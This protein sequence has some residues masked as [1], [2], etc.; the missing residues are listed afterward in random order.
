MTASENNGR[1]YIVYKISLFFKLLGTVHFRLS[2]DRDPIHFHFSWISK[3]SSLFTSRF[4][5]IS[6]LRSFLIICLRKWYSSRQEWSPPPTTKCI[7]TPGLLIIPFLLGHSFS[8]LYLFKKKKY[9]FIYF[10]LCW[11]FVSVRGLSLVAASGGHSSSRC[12]GLSL[13]R[14]LVAEHRL[15]SHRLSSCGSRAQ[16]L[17]SM[18]D[19]PRPGLEPVPC[20]L[21]GRFS[22]TAPPGKP[23]PTFIL[24]RTIHSQLRGFS[25]LLHPIFIESIV[26]RYSDL[27]RYM[28]TV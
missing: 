19:P 4:Y 15:Q 27:Q 24:V 21:A 25:T 11:V 28:R 26:Y 14:P 22:T 8:P 6:T 7:F 23:P 13:S 3:A 10:W 18:W 12:A 20:A 9:V 16:L 17:C 1:S 2:W 5:I